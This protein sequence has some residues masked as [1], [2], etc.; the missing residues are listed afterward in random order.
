[1]P[2]IHNTYFSDVQLSMMYTS[3]SHWL[4]DFNMALV[5]VR[6]LRNMEKCVSL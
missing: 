1:M 3:T 2:K 6:S 4:E 5:K